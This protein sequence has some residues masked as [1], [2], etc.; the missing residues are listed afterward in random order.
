MMAEL[1]GL[2]TAAP[3]GCICFGVV[4]F[5]LLSIP[6][7][8]AGF[9]FLIVLVGVRFLL[10]QHLVDC[11]FEGQAPAPSEA[12]ALACKKACCLASAVASAAALVA[13]AAAAARE[14]ARPPRH[15]ARAALYF[16]PSMAS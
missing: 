3:H 5:Y 14:M 8:L 2:C 10:L 11:C 16:F 12:G 6:R 15:S 13:A 9:G 4:D 7:A 1:R